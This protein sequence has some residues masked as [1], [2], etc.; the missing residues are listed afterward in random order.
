M[1]EAEFII[2]TGKLSGN[3]RGGA[4]EQGNV[5]IIRNRIEEIV[6]DCGV[7]EFVRA[8]I[9]HVIVSGDGEP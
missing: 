6:I 2:R 8:E 3:W 7:D 9:V 1:N 4:I 5:S